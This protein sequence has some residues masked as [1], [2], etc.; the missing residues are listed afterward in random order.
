MI[1]VG[2]KVTSSLYPLKSD[3]SGTRLSPVRLAEIWALADEGGCPAGFVIDFTI[4]RNR[5]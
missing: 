1:N 3:K 2:M 5:W 4:V